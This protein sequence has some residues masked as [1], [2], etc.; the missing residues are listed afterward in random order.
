MFGVYISNA[1]TDLHTLFDMALPLITGLPIIESLTFY[2]LL[3]IS[4]PIIFI[5]IINIKVPNYAIMITN[6]I[7]N[8]NSKLV[9]QS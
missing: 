8:F 2:F 3:R 6:I 1:F 4:L 7:T 9:M 5:I